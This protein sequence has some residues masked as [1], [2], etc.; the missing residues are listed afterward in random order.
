[1]L[2]SQFKLNFAR[3]FHDQYYKTVICII[4][5]M[6]VKRVITKGYL[7]VEDIFIHAS[8]LAIFYALSRVYYVNER[9]TQ[10]VPYLY[11]LIAYYS[12]TTIIF[13]KMYDDPSD[14]SLVHM[15]KD[16]LLR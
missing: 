2:L 6:I 14:P 10:Y 5:L 12:H 16:S 15:S 13:G 9:C 1:M 8:T 3:R 4:S 11:T 7:S